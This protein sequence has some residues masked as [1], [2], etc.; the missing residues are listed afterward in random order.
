MQQLRY[1]EI[2]QKQAAEMMGI[3]IRQ[4]QRLVEQF[5]IKGEKGLVH[6]LRGRPSNRRLPECWKEWILREYR[7]GYLGFGPTLASEKLKE[8]HD[9]PVHRE[10][11]RR[12]LL[13]KGL[14][15]RQRKSRNHHRRW[16]HRRACYGEMVQ[17]DGSHHDWFEGRGPKAVLMAYVD[18]ATGEVFAR[19]YDH[20]GTR[21]ALDGLRSYIR[22]HGI[23]ATLYMDRHRAYGH[24][25]KSAF[26]EVL[27][28][29]GIRLITAHS[30]QAKGRVERLFKTLQDRLV[31]EM[32]LQRI[33]TLEQANQWLPTF[34][35]THNARFRKPPERSGNFHEP[36]PRHTNLDSIF[37][38]RRLSFL[39]NDNTVCYKNQLYQM[40]DRWK[41]SRAKKI[42]VEERLNGS[43]RFTYRGR[44]LS[45]QTLKPTVAMKKAA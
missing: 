42:Q 13:E 28:R 20:E 35:K 2:R 21:P 4:V 1:K 38:I 19:F 8:G 44:K 16:R 39:R 37:S 40:L 5:E 6:G 18:D 25:V 30:P 31:K 23:P 43:I 24:G 9:M 29:L 14:W 32:R 10:T 7:Q 3:S 33:K 27:N 22:K 34:L 17:V 15:Q 26:G 11:L 12:W 45:Y 36:L 41:D